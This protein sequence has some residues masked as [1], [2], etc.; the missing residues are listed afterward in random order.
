MVF[1]NEKEDAILGNPYMP[2]LSQLAKDNAYASQYYATVHPSL[3]NY[4]MLTAGDTISNDLNFNKTVDQDNLI[5][6][7]IKAGKTWKAY[8][9]SIP[10]I[11]YLGDGPYPYV[12]TH[13][14]AAYYSDIRN[15]PAQA[16]NMVGLDQLDADLAAGNLP[17]FM[18]IEPNQ[19]NTMHDCPDGTTN[20][21]NDT[22]VHGGDVWASQRIPSIINNPVFQKD[23]LLIITFDESWDTDS[24]HTGGHV[25][26]IFIGPAVKKQF[27]STSFYQHESIL[28]TICDTVGVPCMGAASSAPAMGEFFVSSK[29]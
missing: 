29:P 21:D 9:E 23:G 6:E 7:I 19:M 27:V 25:L 18:F 12:K 17:D 13:N 22:R 11:G 10:S 4:F 5:R 16:A 24:Q 14:P 26:T 8:E 3:G 1:E 15:N 2:Y 20:C 28:R